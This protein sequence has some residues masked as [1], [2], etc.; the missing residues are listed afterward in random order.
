[1]TKTNRKG[2]INK[3]VTG[4]ETRFHSQEPGG[5]AYYSSVRIKYQKWSERLDRIMVQ[6]NQSGTKASTAGQTWIMSHMLACLGQSS[7]DD[8]VEC[9][10]ANAGD[11][12]QVSDSSICTYEIHTR[13]ETQHMWRGWGTTC[14]QT[15]D[16]NLKADPQEAEQT[17]WEW[18]NSPKDGAEMITLSPVLRC[19]LCVGWMFKR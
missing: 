16:S 10:L 3:H 14:P 12:C 4:A 8:E 5:K 11:A 7:S 15:P 17:G 2:N 9:V 13:R 1:M 6:I 18:A 19:G